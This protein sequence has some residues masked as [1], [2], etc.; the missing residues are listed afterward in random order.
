VPLVH[1]VWWWYAVVCCVQLLE[2][3]SRQFK[4]DDCT[5]DRYLL[6]SQT[7]SLMTV[8]FA[9]V[10]IFFFFSLP[11]SPFLSVSSHVT[12]PAEGAL[13]PTYHDC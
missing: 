1:G 5:L 4:N 10:R 7:A 2:P 9:D 8:T 3:L 11:L 12:R 6:P 13:M